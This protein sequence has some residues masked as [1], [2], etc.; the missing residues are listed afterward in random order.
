[1]HPLI[2]GAR[3]S[4][5]RRSC[6]RRWARKACGTSGDFDKA[7]AEG[8]AV[9]GFYTYPF[10]SHAPL[11]PQNTTANFKDGAVEIWSPTQ[12]PDGALRLVSG[13]LGITPDKVTLHQTRVGGGFGR[14]LMNDYMCEA[15]RSRNRPAYPSS[16]NGR[17]KTT[18]SM[19][20]IG[21]AVST[22]SRAAVDKQGK[23]V[24][25]ADHFITFTSD[26]QGRERRRHR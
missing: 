26:G 8:T 2:A 4:R 16:C 21:S 15:A 5:R 12:T 11:E 22:H 14:R 1:M 23:L 19:T 3:P 10:V 24:G 7:V 6:P 13:V 18:C 9:E 20:S 17:V 25:F